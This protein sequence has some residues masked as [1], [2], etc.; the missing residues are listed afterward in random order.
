MVAKEETLAT[1]LPMEEQQQNKKHELCLDQK[2][3]KQQH[4][5]KHNCCQ[6]QYVLEQKHQQCHYVR[7]EQPIQSINHIIIICNNL[8]KNTY[9]K[10]T[11]TLFN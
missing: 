1:T 6:Q 10:K 7:Q 9:N 4:L 11:R 5:S 3:Q 8:P 2:H